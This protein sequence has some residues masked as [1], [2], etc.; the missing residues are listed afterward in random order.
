MVVVP[1]G[2]K[3]ILLDK[4]NISSKTENI[5]N[6]QNYIKSMTEDSIK[7]H[8]VPI[9]IYDTIKE[10]LGIHGIKLFLDD[11]GHVFIQEQNQS[12]NNLVQFESLDSIRRVY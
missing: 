8:S 9:G 5:L 4:K 6:I 2:K 11:K 3:Y 12:A 10:K 1:V 7:G